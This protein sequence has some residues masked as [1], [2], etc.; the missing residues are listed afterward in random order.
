MHTARLRGCTP[1]RAHGHPLPAERCHLR[2]GGRKG[3][4][5]PRQP[6][7]GPRGA[8]GASR[9]A[10]RDGRLP[11]RRRG[12]GGFHPHGRRRVAP[13]HRSAWP[14]HELRRPCL[15]ARAFHRRGARAHH[16]RTARDR[17]LLVRP[18]PSHHLQHA[19]RR[20][21]LRRRACASGLHPLPKATRKAR[22]RGQARHPHGHGHDCGALAEGKRAPFR[23][24]RIRRGERLH[25]EGKS[26]RGWPRRGLA[27][28]LQKRDAQPSHRNRAL[29]R[30]GHLHRWLHTRPAVRA[31]VGLSSH[32]RERRRR[33][34][35]AVFRDACRQ[36]AAA[37][38]MR[39]GCGRVFELRQPDR[40]RHRP[41]ERDLPPGVCRQAHGGGRGRGRG[42]CGQ[43]GSRDACARRRGR[44]RGRAHGTR[45]HRRSH[46]VEQGTRREKRGH[47]RRR[48]TKRQRACR[49]QNLPTV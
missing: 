36:I 35:H 25:G 6:R 2:R 34:A 41:G 47:L 37:Q 14:C 12:A 29:R 28:L 7:R 16:H 38:D 21:L 44:A 8:D 39:R 42:T 10:I 24:R 32:A 17:H 11:C 22:A 15:R 5:I 43:R 46:R 20:R 31:R 18:L 13:L 1:H 19:A 30:G 33:P 49:A 40:H 27:A 26:R 9:G 48:G 23:P 3:K 4:G 45:R